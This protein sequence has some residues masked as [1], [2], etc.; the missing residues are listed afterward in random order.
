MCPEVTVGMLFMP[1]IGAASDGIAC[2]SK[3]FTPGEFFRHG[4][5][6]SIILLVVLG[7]AVVTIQPLP[8]MPHWS[9]HNPGK[10]HALQNSASC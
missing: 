6:M 5:P 7:L 1:L 3:Q 8:G 4:V 10:S 2:E 9:S